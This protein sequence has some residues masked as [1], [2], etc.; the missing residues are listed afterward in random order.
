[1]KKRVSMILA[2]GLVLAGLAACGGKDAPAEDG[3]TGDGDQ[4]RRGAITVVSREEGSGTRGAFVELLGI[5]QKDAG[6]EK[7]DHTTLEAEVTN[8]TAVMLTT[9]ATNDSA[10]G[11]LSMGSLNNTVK[12]LKIDGVEATAEHVKDGS[13]AVARPFNVVTKETLSEVAQ[14]FLNFILSAEGQAVVEETG[15]IS[16]GNTGAY[17]GTKPAGSITVAGSSSVTPVM[18]KLKEAYLTYNPNASIE[19]QQSDSTTGV[20]SVVEGV[21]DIGMASRDLKDSELAHGVVN[22]VIARDGIAIIVNLDND[23][24]DLKA[25]QVRDI[26]LGEITDWSDVQ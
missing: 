9:V 1:M 11:Y 25:E 2:A 12:A 8:S 26:Y 21:C 14:D 22:T 23:I 19:V 15:Y 16:E 18:E 20:S 6:G 24:E 17:T 3:Y 7:V 10:I 13:Y 4:G 5:E